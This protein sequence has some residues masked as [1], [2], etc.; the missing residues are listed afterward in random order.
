MAALLYSAN[1]ARTMQYH[2]FLG[3]TLRNFLSKFPNSSDGSHDRVI[4]LFLYPTMDFG[5]TPLESSHS[6]SSS[7]SFDITKRNGAIM[8]LVIIILVIIVVFFYFLLR[9]RAEDFEMNQ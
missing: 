3:H 6:T 4:Y 8:I 9:S 1:Y 7:Q 5:W 2:V